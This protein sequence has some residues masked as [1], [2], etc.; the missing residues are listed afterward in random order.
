[1]EDLEY[2]L[3]THPDKGAHALLDAGDLDGYYKLV[4]KKLIDYAYDQ[5]HSL[6]SQYVEKES[7]G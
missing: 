2:K 3:Y 7:P 1:M 5:I 6:E 4:D